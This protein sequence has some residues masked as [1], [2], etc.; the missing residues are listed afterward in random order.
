MTGTADDRSFRGEGPSAMTAAALAAA[1]L[2]TGKR[3]YHESAEDLW[4]GAVES[5]SNHSEDVWVR[6]SGGFP[7]H[8]DDVAGRLV[9]STADLL[10][11]I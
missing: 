5:G 4:R 7:E 11:A 2:A 1:A 6:T 3:E 8:R 10:L 9:R